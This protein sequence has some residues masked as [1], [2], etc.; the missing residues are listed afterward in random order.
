MHGHSK[1]RH[2]RRHR[3]I[4]NYG[5]KAI[6]KRCD[7]RRFLKVT[8]GADRMSSR[9]AFQIAGASKERL[10]LIQLIQ[11]GQEKMY[12]PHRLVDRCIPVSRLV[13]PGLILSSGNVLFRVKKITPFWNGFSSLHSSKFSGV[14]VGVDPCYVHG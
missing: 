9:R 10:F 14:S 8:D 7:F 6:S 12:F 11:V 13:A 1:D 5:G 3:K 2:Q 4:L